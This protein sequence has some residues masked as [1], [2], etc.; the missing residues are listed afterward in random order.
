LNGCRELTAGWL[1]L[2]RLG[3]RGAETQ[4]AVGLERAHAQCIGQGDGLALGGFGL[5]DRWRVTLRRDLAE[6][7]QGI[8]LVTPFLVGTGMRQRIGGQGVRLHMV[9]RMGADG[10]CADPA[11]RR[12]VCGR[13]VATGSG[14]R[15]R[16]SVGPV[17]GLKACGP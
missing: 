6:E 8:R 13:D 9:G 11:D 10:C 4:V 2:A 3:I 7:V 16:K 14:A 15:L 5:F 12:D 1:R 17:R